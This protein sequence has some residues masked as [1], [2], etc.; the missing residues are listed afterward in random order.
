M[1]ATVALP[2]TIGRAELLQCLNDL[3]PLPQATLDALRALRDENLGSEGCA[4]LIGHDPALAARALRLAN[5]AFYGVP[6]RVVHLR[7]AVHLLGRRT[8]ASLVA[9]ALLVKQIDTSLCPAFSSTMFWRHAIATAHAARELAQALQN[10][11][12][13]AFVAGLL[14]D[15]GRLAL[16][17]HFPVEVGA[18]LQLARQADDGHGG[19][20]DMQLGVDHVEVGRQVALH[21]CFPPAVAQA[22][23]L[24][25]APAAAADGRASLSDIVHVANAIAHALDLNGDPYECVPPLDAGAWE[26]LGL[27]PRALL[28]VLRATERGV[29]ELSLALGVSPADSKEAL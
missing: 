2:T 21:W 28:P 16:A 18:A 13:L 10:D 12:E 14:H 5:S 17:A 19:T 7:D 26:R 11:P 23:A 8:L 24:H 9:V 27:Q 25:H 29:A 15:V 20:E 4:E 22:V 1:S 6:G 3:P